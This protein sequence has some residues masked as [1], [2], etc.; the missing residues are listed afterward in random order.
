VVYEQET[1]THGKIGLQL[2]IAVAALALPVASGAA[3][4]LGVQGSLD[5]T[6]IDFDSG[7]T[8]TYDAST[9]MFVVSSTVVPP[10]VGLGTFDAGG[11]LTISIQLDQTGALVN[12]LN[13]VTVLSGAASGVPGTELLTADV[14]AFGSENGLANIDN[15]DFYLEVTGGTAASLFG[16]EVGMYFS[17]DAELE[18]YARFTGDFAADFGGLNTTGGIG[19]VVPEP[20]SALLSGIVLGFVALRARRH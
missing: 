5:G 19:N 20:S 14:T 12:G 11:P 6:L 17:T 4:L 8:V 9:G 7:G 1:M 16:D 13:A 15:Y 2:L 10:S 3:G 18:N